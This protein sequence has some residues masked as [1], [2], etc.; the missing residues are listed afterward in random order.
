LAVARGL[1]GGDNVTLS[2]DPSKS[3]FYGIEVTVN[4]TVAELLVTTRDIASPGSRIPL[5]DGTVF[6]FIEV[7][8]YKTTDDL[9][10]QAEIMFT[11]PL[12]WLD[13][14]GF[15]PADVFLYRWHDGAWQALPTVFVKEEG[16]K[17][18]F[19]GT[20]P[21]FSLFAIAGV[22]QDGVGEEAATVPAEEPGV[23][24]TVT[25]TVTEEATEPVPSEPLPADTAPTPAAT[26]SPLLW[27][28]VLALGG[29]LLLRRR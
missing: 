6:Q 16:G 27:A 10:D 1:A 3:A 19:T 14:E 29:M 21:G 18:Y 22:E 26:Q 11:V 28:P 25:V 17:A 4:G 15:D 5:P 2:L 9:I 12:D 7:T 20:S 13:E 24:A 23:A 8:L